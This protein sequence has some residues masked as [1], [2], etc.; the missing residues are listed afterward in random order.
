MRV[1]LDAGGRP[2]QHLGHPPVG[3]V[4]AVE[5]VELVAAVD[6]DAADALVAGPGQ[7]GVGLV[8]AVQDEALGRH[9]RGQRD[10]QLAAGGDVEVHAL[11]V[12]EP[13]HRQ[14]QERLAGV[15]HAVA[16]R[17][18]GLAAPRT[19]VVLVVDEQRRAEL[20]DQVGG[21]APADGQPAVVA[22]AGRVGQQAPRHGTG[23]GAVRIV[24]T[25]G[26][27]LLGG[28]LGL[29]GVGDHATASRPRPFRPRFWSL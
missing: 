16:E 10:V 18:D 2:Q 6:H 3:R 13:G 9:A 20:G 4:Q 17:G 23:A 11:L 22:D 14:A 28:A 24:G 7:L 1:R 19:Q 21:R 26:R 5:P 29:A 25:V 8:V 12:D 27:R 15:A